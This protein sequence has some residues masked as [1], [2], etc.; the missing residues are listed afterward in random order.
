MVRLG[1]HHGLLGI[2]LCVALY[3]VVQHAPGNRTAGSRQVTRAYD[4]V[5]CG[6]GR[7][8]SRNLVGPGGKAMTLCLLNYERAR[9]GL[10]PLVENRQLD[11]AS[12]RHSADM[13]ARTFFEHVNPDGVDPQTRI[14][15][16]GYVT[17][18]GGVTGENIEW[19]NGALVSPAAMVD[20]WMHSPGHRENILRPAFRE[21]DIG[22]T[23]GRAPRADTADLRAATYTT[24]FGG[25]EAG[26]FRRRGTAA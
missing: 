9:A 14:A 8:V 22:I 10:A 25:R 2:V 19:G 12:E 26:R 6:R 18:P 4:D 17:R 16:A 20:G 7:D 24:D 13:V 5:G 23:M 1:P 11:I 15:V 21:V 3:V